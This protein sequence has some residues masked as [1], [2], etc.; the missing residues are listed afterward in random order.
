MEM[1]ASELARPAAEADLRWW[2]DFA[3]TLQWTWAKTYA[4]FAPHW[5]VMPGRTKGFEVT[6]AWRVGRVVRTFGEPGKFW[7]R[8]QLYLYTPDRAR[9]FWM[10]WEVPL[11]PEIH[12]LVN[13][14]TTER[15]YGPQAD[16]DED[17]LR[18]I[19]LTRGDDRG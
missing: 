15:T 13:L 3:P 12:Q 6:D 11:N 7:R 10:M 14:A 1:S 9:K 8:T 16:F 5:Y 19:R 2:F 17:W 4:E 18:Q